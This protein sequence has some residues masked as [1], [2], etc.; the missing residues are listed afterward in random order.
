MIDLAIAGGLIL[1]AS[2]IGI[3]IIIRGKINAKAVA[4]AERI[5][6]RFRQRY[7]NKALEADRWRLAYEEKNGECIAYKVRLHV[8]DMVYGGKKVSECKRK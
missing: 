8:A 7:D 4:D 1:G 2:I 5:E 6:A 3:A